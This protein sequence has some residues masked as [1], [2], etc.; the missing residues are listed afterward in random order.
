MFRVVCSPVCGPVNY[1][2]NKAKQAP[3]ARFYPLEPTV[4]AGLNWA[5]A[6]A[7]AL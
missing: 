6:D 7:L 3:R 5:C 2:A 4:K 1:A